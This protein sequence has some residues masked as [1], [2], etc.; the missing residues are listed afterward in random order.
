M[1][2]ASRRVLGFALGEHHDAELAYSALVMAVAVRGGQVPGVILHTDQGSE[3]TA[4]LVRQACARLGISQSMGRPGS[5]LDNAVIESWHSTLEFELP[6]ARA[7][8]H[9]GR[10]PGPGQRLDRGLQPAPAA[11]RAGHDVP[12]RLRAG[13]SGR[14]GSLRCPRFSAAQDPPVLGPVQVVPPWTWACAPA[15]YGSYR[16]ARTGKISQIEVST[17][18]G[19]SRGSR[20]GAGISSRLGA[21]CPPGVRLARAR[22]LCWRGGGLSVAAQPGAQDRNEVVGGLV[23]V[24]V[25][26][27]GRG[28]EEARTRHYRVTRPGEPT[29]RVRQRGCPDSTQPVP[30]KQRS[31]GSERGLATPSPDEKGEMTL[32]LQ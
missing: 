10:G 29:A 26:A 19:E 28:V 13:T 27:G 8:H 30:R 18:S 6:L 31:L 5:A 16:E 23:P 4:G 32:A 11:L 3:Y 12:G 2:M 14:E 25:E 7:L 17:L 24:A 1:D 22:W 15:E 21:P 9:Q 20:L